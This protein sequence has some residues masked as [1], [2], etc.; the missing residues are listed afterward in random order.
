MMQ[1]GSYLASFFYNN[2]NKSKKT[3]NDHIHI[4]SDHSPFSSSIEEADEFRNAS[5]CSGVVFSIL[6]FAQL[7]DCFISSWYSTR[8]GSILMKI[9][10][11]NIF[12]VQYKLQISKWCE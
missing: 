10:A 9:C 12:D 1:L 5:L 7:Y 2:K 11:I 3:N 4:T 6:S 8:Y